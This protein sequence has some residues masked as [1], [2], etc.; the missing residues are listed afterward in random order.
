MKV[1]FSIREEG[2][3]TRLSLS[4]LREMTFSELP[5]AQDRIEIPGEEG[6]WLVVYRYIEYDAFGPVAATIA[7]AE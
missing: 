7:L 3:P 2:K 1:S 6:E 5:H 4:P